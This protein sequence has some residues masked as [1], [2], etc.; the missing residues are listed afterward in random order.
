MKP[1]RSA[2]R[3]AQQQGMALV[4]ALIAS[5]VLS[6]GLLG[7]AQLA[8]K[9]QQT[10]T[11]NRQNTVGQMLALEAID[12]LQNQASNQTAACPAQLSIVVQGTSYTRQ[13][14]TL[15]QGQSTDLLVQVSW[16]TK[17]LGGASS[18]QS[19]PQITWRSSVSNLP[20]WVGV[21]LP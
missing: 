7:A 2:R 3:P 18:P 16:P 1:L 10:A 4:E 9:S 19:E 17:R 5:T 21:S 15:P 11:E 12:C 20:S 8:L 6:L 14:Q 13:A